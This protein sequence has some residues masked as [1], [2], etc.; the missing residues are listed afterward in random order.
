MITDFFAAEGNP[1]IDDF[2]D[3]I[4]KNTFLPPLTS[5]IVE[6]LTNFTITWIQSWDPVRQRPL[7]QGS[8]L[9]IPAE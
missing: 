4:A 7:S 2:F 1:V 6:D 3:K 9:P 8:L 5:P